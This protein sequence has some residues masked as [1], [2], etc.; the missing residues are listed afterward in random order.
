M[1]TKKKKLYFQSK[2]HSTMTQ[3]ERQRQRRRQRERKRE[4]GRI[5]KHQKANSKVIT[6]AKAA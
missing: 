2:Q 5:S 6:I 4:T 1:K 3:R